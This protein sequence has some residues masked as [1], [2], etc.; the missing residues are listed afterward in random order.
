V[1]LSLLI[2]F[3]PVGAV[4][5]AELESRALIDATSTSPAAVAEGR[6]I[7]SF[8]PQVEAVVTAPPDGRALSAGPA[9]EIVAPRKTAS[10]RNG[11]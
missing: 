1:L 2:R 6:W 7:V 4:I 9:P 8:V 3:Q 10:A 5:G 11:M